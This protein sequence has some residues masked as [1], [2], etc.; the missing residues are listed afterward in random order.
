MALEQEGF[1]KKRDLKLE[2]FCGDL[3]PETQ[4]SSAPLLKKS[5]LEKKVDD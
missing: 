2:L 4:N 5:L 1:S 3:A